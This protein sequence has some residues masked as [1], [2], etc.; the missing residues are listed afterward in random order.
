MKKD[1]NNNISDLHTVFNAL[2]GLE[3]VMVYTLSVILQKTVLMT[4]LPPEAMNGHVLAGSDKMALQPQAL[5]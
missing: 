4:R 2:T 3:R 5:K 1:E